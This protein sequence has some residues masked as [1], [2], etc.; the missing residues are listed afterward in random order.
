MELIIKGKYV[1]DSLIGYFG[2]YNGLVVFLD[3]VMLDFW[4]ISL[5]PPALMSWEGFPQG[6]GFY[7][8]LENISL[9][10][11]PEDIKDLMEPYL[12]S[13]KGYGIM[14]KHENKEVY[15]LWKERVKESDCN[16]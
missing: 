2:H 13:K 1:G 4:T 14:E 15:G 16:K 3:L 6:K 10:I 7:S 8:E 11:Y 12:T 9:D 5:S